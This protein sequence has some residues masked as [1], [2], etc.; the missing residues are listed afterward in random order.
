MKK[1]AG[2]IFALLLA[3]QANAEDVTFLGWGDPQVTW[4]EIVPSEQPGV[5]VEVVFKNENIHTNEFERLR[6]SYQGVPIEVTID[7]DRA[8]MKP[9]VMAVELPDGYLADPE[10]LSVEEGETGT[11]FVYPPVS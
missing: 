9:D 4:V 7:A 1:G 10:S 5:W 6:M 11:I 2:A 3:G 8:Y